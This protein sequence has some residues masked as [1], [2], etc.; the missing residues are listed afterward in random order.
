MKD[1]EALQRANFDWVVHT[2]CVWTDHPFHVPGINEPVEQE[3]LRQIRELRERITDAGGKQLSNRPGFVMIGP[4]GSGKTHLL[5]SVRREAMQQAMGFVLINLTGVS[6]F[7]ATVLQ[8]ILFSLEQSCNDEKGQ[9][10]SIMEDL[11]GQI[12]KKKTGS[13]A[14]SILAAMKPN[15]IAEWGNK[16]AGA[17]ARRHRLDVLQHQDVIRALLLLNSNDFQVHNIGYSWILGLG[18]EDADRRKFGFQSAQK[19]PVETVKALCWIMSLR[20]PLVIAIDQMDSIVTQHHLSSEADAGADSDPEERSRSLAIIQEIGGGMADLTDSLTHNTFVLLSCLESTWNILQE[21]S[22]STNINRFQLPQMLSPNVGEELTGKLVAQR[23]TPTYHKYGIRPAYPTWPFS[24]KALQELR[25][26]S[27]REIL[28]KCHSCIQGFISRKSIKEIHSFSGESVEPEETGKEIALLELDALFDEALRSANL[29]SIS[30][31]EMEDGVWPDLFHCWFRC[32]LRENPLAISVDHVLDE[33]TLQG[34]K[35]RFLHSRMRLIHR[36]EQDR[37]EQFSVRALLQSNARAFQGRLKAAITES[38]IDAKLKYRKLLIV[39][40]EKAPGGAKTQELLTELHN[41]GGILFPINEKDKRILLALR[42]ME[43]RKMPDWESWLNTRKPASGMALTQ[44]TGILQSS[45]FSAGQERT[46][47]AVADNSVLPEKSNRGAQCATPVIVAPTPTPATSTEKRAAT[48]CAFSPRG[49]LPL[50]KRVIAGKETQ[51]LSLSLSDLKQH[52][53]ILAGSGS[54][55]TVLIRRIL[56]EAALERIPSIVIDCANDLSRLGDRWP[57]ELLNEW[58]TEEKVLADCY[59]QNTE[60]VIWTPGY[61]GGNPLN[62]QPL[63]D[64]KAVADQPD[65]LES[66][67]SMAKDSLIEIVASGNSASA[68][69]KGGILS[70]ALRYFSC[71]GGTLSDFINLL[72]DLPEEAGAGIG[73]AGKHAAEMADLL[74]AE[75]EKN[76]L[77]RQNGQELDPAVLFGARKERTRISVLSLIGLQTLDAQRAFLN[78]LA[79]TLFAWIKQH[80]ARPGCPLTGLLVLDE[81]KDFLPSRGD[82]ACKRSFMRLAAQARKYGLG[83]IIATQA[84][85]D[86]EHT[87]VSNCFTHVYGRQNSPESIKTVQ[88]LIQQKGGSENRI[89][90][91][92]KGEFCLYNSNIA[93]APV[94]MKSPMCL[95]YHASLEPQ[96]VAERAKASRSKC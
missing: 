9:C 68:R 42:D 76:P 85:K 71:T 88:E 62:L 31:E 2:D 32:L 20:G 51:T 37:E 48:V 6:D 19:R 81:A 15:E 50:G 59:H 38:G 53:L 21:K 34:Q 77:L 52:V 72:S 7:W 70:A 61:Q 79:M 8:Q 49:S 18:I 94:K 4:G 46:I 89:A 93:P 26:N 86:I 10:Q 1:L 78:Q 23:L 82:T 47:R 17:L 56:E 80:P 54:G 25:N 95:S 40:P 44:A 92:G 87:I 28:K 58:T 16:I 57:G 74:R 91:Y 39:R 41:A 29:Q 96:E 84:P 75:R 90:T 24:A 3:V 73:E 65:D 30:S 11:L 33:N 63:P 64:L 13:E 69:K 60:V 5:R 43:Q 12:I 83:M 36:N 27:P 35:Y 45:S 22:L 66:A 14:L 55:K 67:I